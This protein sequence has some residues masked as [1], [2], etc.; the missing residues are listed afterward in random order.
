M[1]SSKH[2]F[3]QVFGRERIFLSVWDSSDTPTYQSGTGVELDTEV[4][5]DNKS[6]RYISVLRK[7]V[8]T[9]CRFDTFV[10]GEAEKVVANQ[11]SSPNRTP[12]CMLCDN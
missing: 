3:M 4:S 10:N 6:R 11:R 2:V 12:G 8:P 9:R 1:E 7:T 5:R